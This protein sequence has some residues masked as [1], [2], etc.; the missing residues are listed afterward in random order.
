MPVTGSLIYF[1]FFIK[2]DKT[3]DDERLYRNELPRS[4]VT[5]TK[6]TE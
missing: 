1:P 3:I 4:K 2:S 6:K 5:V